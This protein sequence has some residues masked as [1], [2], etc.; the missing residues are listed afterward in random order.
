MMGLAFPT[1]WKASLDASVFA[2]P[3]LSLVAIVIVAVLYPAAKA[4]MI[5]PVEAIR[6]R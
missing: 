6:S 1:I 2:G 5:Q 3:I 4:A